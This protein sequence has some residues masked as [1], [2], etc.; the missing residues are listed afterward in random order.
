MGNLVIKW[1][2]YSIPV[3]TTKMPK[4]EFGEFFFFPSPKICISE[5]LEDYM[6]SSTVLHE[7]LE[8]VS[9]I[10]DLGLS[11]S[12]I[13]TLEVSLMQIFRQNPALTERVFL[14]RAPECPQ[15]DPGDEDDSKP[16]QSAGRDPEPS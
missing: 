6:Y 1:Y 5:E 9:E 8:M 2:P 3:I 15:S 7:I 14:G 12:K 13:R 10:H 16:I 4:N 11:E